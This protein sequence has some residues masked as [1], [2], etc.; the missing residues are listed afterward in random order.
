MFADDCLI[1]CKVNSYMVRIVKAI[2]EK[3]INIFG[4]MVNSEIYDPILK[5]TINRQKQ[6]IVDI[7]QGASTISTGTYR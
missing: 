2:L 6:D 7:L 3:I 1:F 4:Q 5:R